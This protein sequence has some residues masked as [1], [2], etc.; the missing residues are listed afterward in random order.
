MSIKGLSSDEEISVLK[1]RISVLEELNSHYKEM[2][3]KVS[4][5]R[6][7]AENIVETV[8]EPLL[9]M[10]GELKVFSAN[11][12]FFKTFRVKGEETLGH[13]IYDL[14]N[15]QWN[16][17]E[18][19]KLLKE[20]IS[21]KNTLDDYEIEHNFETIGRK[22][23]LLNARRIPPTPA[24]PRI[25]LLAIEDITERKSVQQEI[26]IGLEQRVEERTK[27]LDAVNRELKEKIMDLEVIKRAAV[28]RELKMIEL[29][30][31]IERLKSEE[32]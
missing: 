22:V 17:P 24:K 2:E 25:I 9:I 6:L 11:K 15:G 14:G 1:K 10:D 5:A 30:K 32:K 26:K 16:I 19:R 12:S 7:Y 31:E 20:I 29:K 23:M 3:G 27:E 4:E 21:K 28:G 18:L 8:R 13:F